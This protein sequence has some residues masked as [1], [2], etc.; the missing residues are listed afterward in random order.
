M[1]LTVSRSIIHDCIG[2]NSTTTY[3]CR[4]P[5][6]TP[7]E[8]PP[9]HWLEMEVGR[10]TVCAPRRHCERNNAL[11]NSAAVATVRRAVQQSAA[12]VGRSAGRLRAAATNAI[13]LSS[14]LF[15]PFQEV[16]APIV[17]APGGSEPHARSQ[18]A[19]GGDTERCSRL[20]EAECEGEKPGF[21]P[22]G[23]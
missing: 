1:R 6:L 14:C 11:S 22:T 16:C 4:F 18:H 10:P 15:P 19:R 5:R 9:L 12:P 23:A 13:L 21:Q 2:Q 17:S 3:T 20:Q 8:P 7:S